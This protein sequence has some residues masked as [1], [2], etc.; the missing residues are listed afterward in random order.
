MREL[1]LG[2]M[3]DF[4]YGMSDDSTDKI[5]TYSLLRMPLKEKPNTEMV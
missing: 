3:M 1:K 5:Y 4:M 2:T